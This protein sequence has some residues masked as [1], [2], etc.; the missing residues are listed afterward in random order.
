MIGIS[1]WSVFDDAVAQEVLNPSGDYIIMELLCHYGTTISHEGNKKFLKNLK[2]QC[3]CMV[4][5]NEIIN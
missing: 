5:I 1:N 3:V 2:W 4:P